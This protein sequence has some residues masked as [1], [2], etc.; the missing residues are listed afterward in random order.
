MEFLIKVNS[1]YKN[2]PAYHFDFND[3]DK[4]TGSLTVD[5][6]LR[7]DFQNHKDRSLD[8]KIKEKVRIEGVLQKI[9]K[10]TKNE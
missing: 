10:I 1:L 4:C 5:A 3:S 8:L 7:K 9:G 2:I 6:L